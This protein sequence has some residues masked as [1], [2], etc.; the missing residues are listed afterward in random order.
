MDRSRKNTTMFS[1]LKYIHTHIF[2]LTYFI[3]TLLFILFYT[4]GIYATHGTHSSLGKQLTI[5]IDA[6]YPVT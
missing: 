4:V 3:P 6:K 2:S 5:G 1:K